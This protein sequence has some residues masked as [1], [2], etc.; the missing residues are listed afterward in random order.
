MNKKGRVAAI[1]SSIIV[2]LFIFMVGGTMFGEM[3][4]AVN[5]SNVTRIVGLESFFP[6]VIVVLVAVMITGIIFSF[7]SS[8]STFSTKDEG[9][10]Y[11]TPRIKKVTGIHECSICGLE[12]PIKYSKDG[13]M[14]CKDCDDEIRLL[15]GNENGNN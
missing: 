10:D 12:K 4:E 7:I 5:S 11:T 1:L 8:T 2:F 14:V 9:F 6:T 13:E 15:G 3:T